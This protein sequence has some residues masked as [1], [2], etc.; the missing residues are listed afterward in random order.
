MILQRKTKILRRCE[1]LIVLSQIEVKEKLVQ[2]K[3]CRYIRQFYWDNF[4]R[5]SITRSI[6]TRFEYKSRWKDPIKVRKHVTL[7]TYHSQRQVIWR[8]YHWW[9]PT[10]DTTLDQILKWWK[11][12][13]PCWWCIQ[14]FEALKVLT[15]KNYQLHQ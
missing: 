8:N 4:I 2:E 1:D 12:T 5:T 6:N 9:H 14:I 10:S 13:N 3:L 11:K 7:H 15:K